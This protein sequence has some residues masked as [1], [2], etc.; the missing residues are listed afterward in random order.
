MIL[1]CEVNLDK[2]SFRSDSVLNW[3]TS[4][5]GLALV[6][7]TMA[8]KSK[9]ELARFSVVARIAPN[10]CLGGLISSVRTTQIF[11]SLDYILS[12]S[13]LLPFCTLHFVHYS[14]ENQT[15]TKPNM[16]VN[17]KVFFFLA[18]STDIFTL[19]LERSLNFFSSSI[20]YY[21]WSSPYNGVNLWW[22]HFMSK[23]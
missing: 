23:I 10:F 17:M 15:L 22:T 1:C 2:V 14:Q 11:L 12:H 7:N 13:L 20:V 9:L 19:F 6:R 3:T 8:Q 16:Q 4:R 5:N 18:F 21:R